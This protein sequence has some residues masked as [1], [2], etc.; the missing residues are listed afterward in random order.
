MWQYI[1]KR[2]LL[3]IPSLLGAALVV[4]L[5]MHVVPGDIALL[6]LGTGEQGGD[7]N[8]QDLERLREKMG[9]NRPLY[10]QFLS[11]VWNIVRLDFGTS[12]W[13][14]AP[15]I[16]E[17]RVRL[18]LTLEVAIFATLISTILAIPLGTVAAVRQDTWVDYG[19]RVV[20]IGGLA[21]PAFWTGI[22]IILLLVIYFEWSPPLVFVP[23]WEDPWE[24][25]AQLV[26][27]IVTV[28]YRNAAIGTR[29]TRSAVL[30]V[31]REDY[32]RTAW[33][34]GL[35]ERI[36]VIKH[37]LKNAML[38]VITI[39]GAELAFLLGGLV[40]T[41]TVFTLNGLGRFMVDAILHRDIPVVQTMVL[42]TAFI[43][44]FV[45]L[46]VDLLYAWLDP[47]ISYR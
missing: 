43:I 35:H 42:L 11:W 39:I 31:M 20:S 14:G 17:L 45:N 10:E 22:L 16:E 23:F 19:V 6:I 44:V 26:F 40:V 15:V 4:F 47:R 37:T 5:L 41:E 3:M 28:G 32:I 27:P 8:L 1:V 36:V 2:I 12:L 7:V 24:N 18:P 46:I 34:K 38:P 13:S 30:E 25:F 9:L 29:M 33:A 21:I